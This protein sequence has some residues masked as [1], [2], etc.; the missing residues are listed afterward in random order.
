[1]PKG[2]S[3]ISNTNIDEKEIIKGEDVK[4]EISK[5]GN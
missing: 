3:V 5:I 1:V 4:G 2:W